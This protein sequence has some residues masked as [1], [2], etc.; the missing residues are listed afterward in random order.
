MTMI[1]E[2]FAVASKRKGY[3]SYVFCQSILGDGAG[4][5]FKTYH[6]TEFSVSEKFQS[7]LADT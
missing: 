1:F 4:W 7:E 2:L 6:T 5:V 3:L